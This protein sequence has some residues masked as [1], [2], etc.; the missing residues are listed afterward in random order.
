[1]TDISPAFVSLLA[2]ALVLL[3]GWGIKR[4][5]TRIG[6]DLSGLRKAD[7]KLWDEHG[8]LQEHFHAVQR[9]LDRHRAQVAETYARS[10]ELEKIND[11]LD[12]L[13]SDIVAEVRALESDV[14]KRIDYLYPPQAASS[15]RSTD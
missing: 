7:E 11:Q 2:N 1:M 15:R 13:R 10:D 12:L 14:H 8:K 5:L 3:V 6:D 9:E 4:E